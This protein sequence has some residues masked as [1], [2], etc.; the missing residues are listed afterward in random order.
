M[1]STFNLKKKKDIR[2]YFKVIILKKKKIKTLVN[3]LDFNIF[4]LWDVKY[5]TI[6][7]TNTQYAP[8][9]FLFKIKSNLDIMF[10]KNT[11]NNLI[12]FKDLTYLQYSN[13]VYYHFSCLLTHIKIS[14][15][16]VNN[17]CIS[18]SN[19]FTN[20]VW[21]E[22]EISEFNGLLFK[23]LK[24]NRKLLLDYGNTGDNIKLNY[25]HYDTIIGEYYKRLLRWF[26]L[27]L[28]L[29]FSI[30]I[31]FWVFKKSLFQIIILS[32]VIVILITL[33]LI[34]LMLKLN[35]YYLV[36]FSLIIL[37]FGGLELSLNL[38]IL[39]L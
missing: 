6:F 35:I 20:I 19:F 12:F 8:N 16:K 36:G 9:H 7:K 13:A 31:T 24:D 37:I 30:I 25:C 28:F 10:F 2:H 38:L 4:M 34:V 17:N 27:F 15:F 18:F 23:N 21:F 14:F 26:F 32:E 1:C 5:L 33:L 11:L 22:R 39:I 29:I 3:P